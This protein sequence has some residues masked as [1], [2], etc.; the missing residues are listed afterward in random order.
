MS[1]LELLVGRATAPGA[2]IT[3]LTATAGTTFTVRAAPLEAR[4]HLATAW[5]HTQ[6]AGIVRIRSPRLHDNVQGIRAR[7]RA[8]DQA[9]LL[10]DTVQQPLVP[11]DTLLV[12]ATGSAGAGHIEQ[13]GMLIAYSDLPGVRARLIGPEELEGRRRNIVPVE[14]ALTAGTT[15]EFT[16]ER[17]L[18][19]DFDLLKSGA[20]YALVGYLVDVG[21]AAVGWRSADTGNVRVGGPGWAAG[22]EVTRD[23]FVRLSAAA[24]MP[25]IPVVSAANRLGTLVDVAQ[26]QAGGAVVL[27]SLLVELG[28]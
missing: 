23:W 7:H 19:A 17:T 28:A 18:V 5:A 3:A 27:T 1:A 11:G 16:G 9:P 24:G 20:D 25:L 15:G 8:A 2:A 6:A 13:A 21:C 10:P 4:T 26:N 14:T 22:R 12:E